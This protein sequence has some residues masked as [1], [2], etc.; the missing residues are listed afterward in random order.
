M[1]ESTLCWKPKLPDFKKIFFQTKEMSLSLL[2]DY[3]SSDESGGEDHESP[4]ETSTTGELDEKKLIEGKNFF[5]ASSDSEVS[6]SGD[7]DDDDEG[8]WTK[9][10]QK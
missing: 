1:R 10:N 9:A 8:N 4:A 7:S 6:G 5:I 3:D 2:N